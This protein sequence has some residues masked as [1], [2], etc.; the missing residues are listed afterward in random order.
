MYKENAKHKWKRKKKGS[1]QR[2]KKNTLENDA[3][4]MKSGANCIDWVIINMAYSL[5]LITVIQE[6]LTWYII[7]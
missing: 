6:V 4:S 7:F 1:F 5:F 2:E 3:C